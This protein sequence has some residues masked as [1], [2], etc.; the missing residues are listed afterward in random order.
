MFFDLSRAFDTI[1][2]TLLLDTL[3]HYGI[4]GTALSWIE[5]YLNGR[6]QFVAIKGPGNISTSSPLAVST[7]VPQGS[8][9]GPLLFII[10]INHI[11][12]NLE[13]VFISLFADDTT[14]AIDSNAIDELSYKATAT[15]KTM[16][17]YCKSMGL[18]LNNLKTDLL[19]FSTRTTDYSLLVKY[20]NRSITQ[21]NHVKFLGVYID[22]LLNWG[23]HIDHLIKKISAQCF[24]IWQLR[25]FI[26]IHILKMY[27]FAHVQSQLSYCIICW[28]NC[29]RFNEVFI[30]QKKIIRTM[31]FKPPQYS[32]R[33]LF[34]ELGILTA[35]ALYILHSVLHV[36]NNLAHFNSR[37]D[38]CI[39]S[40]HNLREN[41]SLDIPPHSLSIL[42]KSHKV[43]PIKLFNK[44]PLNIKRINVIHLFKKEVKSLLLKFSFYSVEEYLQTDF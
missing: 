15:V 44:L 24:V 7:G 26:N 34:S 12:C 38:T 22:S 41:Y 30:L 9:L 39:S 17:N 20:D 10:F 31:S 23:N 4:R 33:K 21:S 13:N 6:T 16:Q 19:L 14:I 43:T 25:S 35:P 42:A 27:Y 37:H 2:H 18:A 1:N 29:S 5:S 32:C 11:G 3:E 8:I 40:G 36:K 28:G